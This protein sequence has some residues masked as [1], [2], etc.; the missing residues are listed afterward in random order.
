MIK[1]EIEKLALK[2]ITRKIGWLSDKLEKTNGVSK[3][4]AMRDAEA[5][6]N[7]KREV[8]PGDYA[9]LILEEREMNP[10]LYYKR[11][12]NTW[13]RDTSIEPTEQADMSSIFCN[14]AEKCIS[15]GDNCDS[16]GKAALDIQK[17]AMQQMTKEFVDNLEEGAQQIEEN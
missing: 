13:E 3:K 8:E 11:R 5:M 14:T 15:V 4:N 2:M 12:D 6:I 9:V 1:K 7:G 10:V 17:I 16:I